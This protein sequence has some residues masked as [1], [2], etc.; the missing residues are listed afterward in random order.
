M[1]RRKLQFIFLFLLIGYLLPTSVLAQR[2]PLRNSRFYKGQ[3]NYGI[4]RISIGSGTA[5]YFGDLCEWGDCFNFR[6]QFS[7]GYNYRFTARFSLR[8]EFSYY[9]LY[10]T[11]KGGKNARRNLSFRSGNPEVYAAAQF[12]I[13]PYTKFYDLRQFI[14]PYVFAGVGLT[15]INPK[16]ELD[17]KWYS[18]APLNTEGVDYSRFLPIIP[19]GGGITFKMHPVW[20]LSFEVAYRLTFSDYMDDVSTTFIDN[21]TL[22]PVAAALADRSYEVGVKP[23]NSNDGQHWAPGHKRGNPGKNDGYL[24]MGFKVEYTLNPIMRPKRGMIRS[25]RFNTS[26]GNSFYKGGGAKKRKRR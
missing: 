16:A 18:L 24:M 1:N 5:S 2:G 25:P 9:R 3:S 8:G 23:W 26:R 12:D 22:P 10:A 7:L 15:N 19:F 11:D 21:N 14:R 13:F 6:P 4:Q 17:G 20:D